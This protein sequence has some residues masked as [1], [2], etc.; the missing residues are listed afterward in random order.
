M[1]KN[2]IS[3]LLTTL[4]IWLLIL[5]GTPVEGTEG[6]DDGYG[7]GYGYGYGFYTLEEVQSS[8]SSS[9]S[10]GSRENQERI[11]KATPKVEEVIEG[12]VV[13]TP[14]RTTPPTIIVETN[15]IN[16]GSIGL[17]L[18]G[19]MVLV[20]GGYFIFKKEEGLLFQ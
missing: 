6:Y 19:V 7:Y 5:S 3:A 4:I 15:T 2:I 13:I 8:S 12:A 1:N 9:T 20:V 11:I 14:V 17:I 18:L 10:G 16:W